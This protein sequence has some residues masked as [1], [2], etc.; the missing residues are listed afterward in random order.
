[1]GDRRE[2]NPPVNLGYFENF[3]IPQNL[4]KSRNVAYRIITFRRNDLL[5]IVYL[6]RTSYILHFG[7]GREY[8][9]CG[10]KNTNVLCISTCHIVYQI[11]KINDKMYFIFSCCK[12]L[13]FTTLPKVVCWCLGIWLSSNV[14][15]VNNNN[16]RAHLRCYLIYIIDDNTIILY[17]TLL[18]L[19]DSSITSAAVPLP[20]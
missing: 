17:I 6:F 10:C 12:Y 11:V 13:I 9:K 18:I 15:V 5:S 1:M 8:N 14:N 19:P 20:R 3:C 16:G 7:N 4:A 2:A